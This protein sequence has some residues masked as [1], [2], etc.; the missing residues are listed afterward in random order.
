MPK[1]NIY[2]KIE[3]N[4]SA[5]DLFYDLNVYRTDASNKNIYYCQWRNNQ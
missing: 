1:Y 2:T 5:V 3:S 4:V